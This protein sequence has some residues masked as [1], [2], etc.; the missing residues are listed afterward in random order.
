MGISGNLCFTLW[1]F[2]NLRGNLL[3]M[4]SLARYVILL[5]EKFPSPVSLALSYGRPIRNIITKEM[6]YCVVLRQ[7][8]R[9]I[10]IFCSHSRQSSVAIQIMLMSV[11]YLP[12]LSGL[13]PLT[14]FRN[15]F[16]QTV[17]LLGRVIS[18][19][20]GLYLNTGQH[21]QNKRIHKHTKHSCFNWDSN[22]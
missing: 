21:K 8:H 3:N 13:G 17:G 1:C 9:N 11:N 5:V 6:P 4:T 16:S 7:L 18:P 12:A 14:K 10:P 15:H 19:L 20:Q 22:P 2:T